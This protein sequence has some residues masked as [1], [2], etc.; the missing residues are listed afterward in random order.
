VTIKEG[1]LGYTAKA[2]IDPMKVMLEKIGRLEKRPKS[3]KCWLRCG[4]PAISF[5]SSKQLCILS[6]WSGAKEQSETFRFNY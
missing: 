5:H 6:A 4:A 1:R 3:R 2:V